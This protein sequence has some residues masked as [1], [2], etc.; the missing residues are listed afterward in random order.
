MKEK[1]LFT[2]AVQLG[3]VTG[4]GSACIFHKLPEGPALNRGLQSRINSNFACLPHKTI[5]SDS[6]PTKWVNRNS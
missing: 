5:V 4:D 6:V 3:L 2:I 1:S